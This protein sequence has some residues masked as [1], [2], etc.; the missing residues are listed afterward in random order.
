MPDTRLWTF[1]LVRC[2]D[3]S[4]Y[5]GI[6]L[7]AEERVRVHNAGLGADYT[8]RRRPVALVYTETHPTKSSARRREIQVKNWS[9]AKK[10]QLVRGFPS[11]R[12]R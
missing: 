3:R 8:A 1:Y 7:D 12:S 9:T 2:S 11:A 10:E 4:L 6:A 5:C